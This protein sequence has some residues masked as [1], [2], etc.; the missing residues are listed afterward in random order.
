MIKA[1]IITPWIGDGTE[2]TSYRP[3][4]ADDYKAVRYTDVTEQPNVIPY[5]AI[6]VAEFIV[7][8]AIYEWIESDNNYLVLW[9]EEIEDETIE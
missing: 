8:D 7:E 9:S 6:F 2:D 1:R 4:M 3:Q 5:P